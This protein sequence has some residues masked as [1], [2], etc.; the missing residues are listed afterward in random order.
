VPQSK[1]QIQ[2]K[3]MVLTEIYELAD[4]KHPLFT[5]TP[6]TGLVENFAGKAVSNGFP[7]KIFLSRL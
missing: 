7:V 6:E 5:K 4:D 1:R 2:R 3:R